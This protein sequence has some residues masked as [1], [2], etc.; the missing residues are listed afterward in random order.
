[1]R[2]DRG[3]RGA[4]LFRTRQG[5]SHAVRLYAF[6][7]L[8][9]L[10]SASLPRWSPKMEAIARQEDPVSTQPSIHQIAISERTAERKSC[11]RPVPGVNRRKRMRRMANTQKACRIVSVR[12]RESSIDIRETA[13]KTGFP[14]TF[15][16]WM[17]QAP[18]MP[19]SNRRVCQKSAKRCRM[20]IR[21]SGSSVPGHITIVA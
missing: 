14:H 4:A 15:S 10:M 17:T 2:L 21:L 11:F 6:D 8:R 5:E 19:K 13:M 7:S 3:K 20:C 9:R 18:T 1:M 12:Q 16:R